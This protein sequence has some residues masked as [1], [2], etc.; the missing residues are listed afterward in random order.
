[1]LE[2]ATRNWL[3]SLYIVACCAMAASFALLD[4]LPIGSM[5]AVVAATLFSFVFMTEFKDID[6][7]D[8]RIS[9]FSATPNHRM[10]V[11]QWSISFLT[12]ATLVTLMVSSI[13]ILMTGDA[14]YLDKRF[15]ALA[16][17]SV[18]IPVCII[19]VYRA[20]R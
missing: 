13:K 2:F 18:F 5:C 12:M 17:A 4:S 3:L 6:F 15:A 20:R 9:W 11:R 14:T 7:L 16:G 1:M 19:A 10:S 8:I